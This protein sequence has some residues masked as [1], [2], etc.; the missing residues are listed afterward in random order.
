V[1]VIG[2]SAGARTAARETV[3]PFELQDYLIVVQCR[4]NHAPELHNFVLDTGG[5]TVIDK[6]LADELQLKQQGQQAKIDTFHVG[7]CAV[8]RL[9]VF[10]DFDLQPLR[11]SYGIDV[12]GIIGS[13]LLED[14]LVTIDYEKRRLTLSTDVEGLAAE[15]ESN[16]AGYLLKFTKHPINRA[17]MIRCKLNGSIEVEAMVDTGQ[18]YAL[19]L[20]LKEMER[21]GA[22]Q[23]SSTLKAKGVIVKWPGTASPDNYLAR[24]KSLE[25]DSLKT[26]GIM[27]VFAE[28][29]PLLSVPLLGGDFLSRYLIKL[30]YVHGEMLLVPRTG[31]PGPNHAF[32]TG[33]QL[34]RNA[35]NQLVVRGIWEKSPADRAGIQVGDRILEFNSR[36]VTPELHRELWL[37]LN[38]GKTE[39]VELL[40]ETKAGPRR[41]VLK[42]ANLI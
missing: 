3:I 16:T 21:T 27:T 17:P 36:K 7:D 38:D 1:L 20:P 31:Q 19:A 28:L 4:I 6:A 39:S 32:S 11:D 15:K 23:Q 33:L 10:T 42:K 26:N 8:D 22:S 29:P 35:E 14:Y 13:D 5:L 30:D 34:K 9:F 37:L 2:V 24:L 18:P 12:S 40:I 25:A 41:I